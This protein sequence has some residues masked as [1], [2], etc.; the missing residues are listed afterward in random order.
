MS[1]IQNGWYNV[2]E[3]RAY[4]LDDASTCTDDLG[5]LVPPDILVDAQIRFPNNLGKYL[6][7]SSLTV[8]KAGLVSLTVLA[9]DEHALD[10]PTA[11]SFTP[12]AALAVVNPAPY[13][14]QALQ[15]YMPGV[16]G[17]VVFGNGAT[18]AGVWR[19]STPVQ[20]MLAPRAASSYPPFGGVTSIRLAGSTQRLTGV[21]SLIASGDLVIEP[22]QRVVAGVQRDVILFRLQQSTVTNVFTYYAGKCAQRPEN[23][24]CEQPVV[25]NVGGATPDCSGNIDLDFKTADGLQMF[26]VYPVYEDDT[27]AAGGTLVV[28]YAHGL[29]TV[30]PGETSLPFDLL[31]LPPEESSSS[32]GSGLPF[33]PPPADCQSFHM[34]FLDNFDGVVPADWWETLYGE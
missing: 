26:D 20:A 27:G 19:F 25:N 9:A 34:P 11:S 18:K 8:S 16:S 1:T 14:V 2:N 30:C 4:P 6:F 15:A 32:S 22:A 28:D 33:P 5:R 24:N 31:P 12:V 3:Q 29:T 17:W 7:L 23:N 13:A 10:A 21:I